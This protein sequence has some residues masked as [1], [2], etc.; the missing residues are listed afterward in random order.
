M[1]SRSF[2]SDLCC[3]L[4]SVCVEDCLLKYKRELK[5]LCDG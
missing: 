4:E 1:Y 5:D 2:A 3:A